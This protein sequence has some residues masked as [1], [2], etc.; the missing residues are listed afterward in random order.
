M[1]D[2]RQLIVSIEQTHRHLQAKAVS[3]INQAI[4][5]KQLQV[6]SGKFVSKLSFTHLVELIKIDEPL[7]R[8]FYEIECIKGWSTRKL[9][10]Q[11]SSLPYERSELSAKPEKLAEFVNQSNALQVPSKEQLQ[12][13][14]EKQ[15]KGLI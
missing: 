10:R 2:F 6:P 11:N 8:T 9:K 7:M 1:Q 4:T 13:Y 15:L 14:I 12:Q 5:K 3:E